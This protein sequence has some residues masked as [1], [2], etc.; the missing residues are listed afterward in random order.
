[1]QLSNMAHREFETVIHPYT[2]QATRWAT[3]TETS[4]PGE[5]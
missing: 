2:N 5:G 3:A 1:M 4:R